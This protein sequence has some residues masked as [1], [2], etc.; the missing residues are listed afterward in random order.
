MGARI[1]NRVQ[2]LPY[3]QTRPSNVASISE[4]DGHTELML[5]V[6]APA[7]FRHRMLNR[8]RTCSLKQVAVDCL[9]SVRDVRRRRA[10]QTTLL[11]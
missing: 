9:V 8:R 5:R 4:Q 3:C 2:A 1:L 11:R 7:A 10:T 6:R